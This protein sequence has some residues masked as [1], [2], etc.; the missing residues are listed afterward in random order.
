MRERVNIIHG[1][2]PILLVA[3]HG[4]SDSNTSLITEMTAASTNAYAVINQGFERGENVD[5]DNDVADCNR[6]DHCQS[7][8]VFDEFLKPLIKIKDKITKRRFST[9]N[10][11]MVFKKKLLVVYVHGAGDIVHK[12]ANEPVDVIVGYGLGN[13]KDSLTCKLST[14]NLFINTWRDFNDNGGEVYEGSGSGRYAGRSSNNMNQYFKQHELDHQVES[15]QLEFPYSMR[16]TESLATVTA[17]M[18]SLVLNEMMKI[19]SYT[20]QPIKK[21]I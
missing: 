13:N 2:Q 15:I 1:S 8:I 17:M 7:E 16:K 14:K 19:D 10:V 11:P 6:V 3:P 9:P 4:P 5:P 18:L 20:D 12:E 21:L